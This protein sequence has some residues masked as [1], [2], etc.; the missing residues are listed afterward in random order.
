MIFLY[1]LSRCIYF[2]YIGINIGYIFPSCMLFLLF[3]NQIFLY[4]ILGSNCA[5]LLG[6][7]KH[8]TEDYNKKYNHTNVIIQILISYRKMRLKES[9]EVLVV[10]YTLLKRCFP[11]GRE[12]VYLCSGVMHLGLRGFMVN[13]HD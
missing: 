10:N 3:F 9:S 5:W 7:R 8:C 2:N 13:P 6:K 11:Y 4:F 12:S 1:Y